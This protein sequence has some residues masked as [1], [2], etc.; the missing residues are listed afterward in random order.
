ML[1]GIFAR[2]FGCLC[3]LGLGVVASHAEPNDDAQLC[4]NIDLA[5]GVVARASSRGLCNFRN[6]SAT[7]MA[8][9]VGWDQCTKNG[10][11]DDDNILA[12]GMKLFEPY[13]NEVGGRAACQDLYHS[14]QDNDD[15]L[16]A[17]ARNTHFDD[18]LDTISTVILATVGVT[19]HPQTESQASDADSSCMPNAPEG[20][21]PQW[22]VD[23]ENT[24]GHDIATSP[25]DPIW[26]HADCNERDHTV[27]W[28]L[29]GGD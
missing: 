11:T 7:W 14:L 5:R 2:L 23:L 13:A 25:T 16:S 20:R 6:D 10:I 8:L 18:K 27:T 21:A 19:A 12:K 1:T 29:P 22:A 24:S 9:N 17:N 15:F 4:R 3:V 26:Q 28:Q